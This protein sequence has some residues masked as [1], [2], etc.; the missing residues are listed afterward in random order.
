MT[1]VSWINKMFYFS[2]SEFSESKKK[3][4]ISRCY[5]KTNNTINSKS[6]PGKIVHRVATTME[7]QDVAVRTIQF[8]VSNKI[9]KNNY[10]CKE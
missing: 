6:I 9:Y 8:L 5:Y 3:V 4:G 7:W 1:L 2:Q 10:Y